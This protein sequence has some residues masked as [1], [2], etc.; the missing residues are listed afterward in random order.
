MASGIAATL[1]SSTT[2]TLLK[3]LGMLGS[4]HAGE[5]A[6]AGLKADQI[7]RQNGLTWQD[8]SRVPQQAQNW[9]EMRNYCAEHSYTLAS[10]NRISLTV[11]PVGAVPPAKNNWLG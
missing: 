2:N 11:L 1:P 7:I 6:A 3:C 10:T 4:N 5:R 9:R 8:L